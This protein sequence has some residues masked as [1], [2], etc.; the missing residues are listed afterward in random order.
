[1][2]CFKDQDIDKIINETFNFLQK[3]GIK[4]D[5][6]EDIYELLS[7]A[8]CDISQDGMVKFPPKLIKECLSSVPKTFKWW[9]RPGTE[10]IEYG[11]GEPCF[12]ADAKAPNYIDPYTG[13]KKMGDQDAVALMAR[14][15]DALPEMDI[16]GTPISTSDFIADNAT[17]I[18]NTSKPV[19]LISGDKP[20]VLKAAIESAVEVRGG[21]KELKE[22]I[23]FATIIS[24]EVLHYPDVV[25]EQ[26]KLCTENNIPTFIGTM[27]I[28]GISSPVTI[29]GTL[30]VCLAT[31]LPGIV[32][33]QLLKKGHP[34]NDSS[35]PTF[36]N[37]ATAGT[38]GFPENIMADMA[39]AKICEKLGL[40]HSQQTGL[41][42]ISSE[43]S[44][45]SI[46]EISWN[47]GELARSSFDA[48][49]GAGCIDSGLTFSPH[50]LV[51]ANELASLARRIWKGIPVDDDSLA[52]EQ[53]KNIE[54]G[55]FIMEEHTALHARQDLWRG[56]YSMPLEQ[57]PTADKKDLGERIDENL[58]KSLISKVEVQKKSIRLKGTFA[59]HG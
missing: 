29:A 34:C 46:A 14:L 48:F 41:A 28:G 58:K 59:L 7:N 36:M 51:F 13:E 40:P 11:S 50:S 17:T 53:I 18:A 24:P 33:A 30:V 32:L 25:I 2:N 6:D 55:M 39:R 54:P 10:F 56:K 21:D 35:F 23:Y 5:K 12:I 26:I 31:V 57:T 20:E 15:V 38:G 4:F 19:F 8:G 47:F 16:C 44:Q 3:T 45:D 22:K 43:F 52:I 37:P 42:A 27:P 9:N 49:W 1:M